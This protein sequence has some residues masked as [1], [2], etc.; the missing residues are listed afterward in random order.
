MSCVAA[1]SDATATATTTVTTIVTTTTVTTTAIG[2]WPASP[3]SS[4]ARGAPAWPAL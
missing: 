3:D 2:A 1:A 4:P